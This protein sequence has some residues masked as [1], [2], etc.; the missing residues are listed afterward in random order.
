MSGILQTL[1][2]V[3]MGPVEDYIYLPGFISVYDGDSSGPCSAQVRYNA[4]NGYMEYMSL[5]DTA[6][7]WVQ[8]DPVFQPGDPADYRIKFSPTIGSVS[9]GSASVN[10]AL[11][12]DTDR[13]WRVDRA[14]SGSKLCQADLEIFH[15]TDLVTPVASGI[16][17]L[18][19]EIS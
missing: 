18:E 10:T 6:G 12:M 16:V 1:I 4:S 9:A 8:M 14:I 2:A 3:E 17:E 7:V 13:L 11:T 19:A 5:V 15:H